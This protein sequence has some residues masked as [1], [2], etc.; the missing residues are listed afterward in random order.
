MRKERRSG[1]C[2][3]SCVYHMYAVLFINEQ[4]ILY[5]SKTYFLRDNHIY[6]ILTTKQVVLFLK[7]AY[8]LR[9]CSNVRLLNIL[10]ALLETSARCLLELVQLDNI[11]A[12]H[13]LVTGRM[14]YIR[15]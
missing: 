14:T 6:H 12:E 9:L 8:R 10:K 5:V 15:D 2:A 11:D 1:D 4:Q 7:I 13:K 3:G